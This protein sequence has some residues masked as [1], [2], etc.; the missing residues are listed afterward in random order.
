MVAALAGIVLVVHLAMRQHRA[1]M[2]RRAASIA[3]AVNAVSGRAVRAADDDGFAVRTAAGVLVEAA[4]N[5][6]QDAAGEATIRAE[7]EIP[8]DL[9]VGAEGISSRIG[10]ALTGGDVETGDDLF[11]REVLLR[12]SEARLVAILDRQTR[13]LVRAAVARGT[14]IADG[15]ASLVVRG[16][17]ENPARLADPAVLL[18]ALADAIS[19]R[20]ALPVAALLRENA[21]HDPVAAVRRRNLEILADQFPA[22]AETRAALEAAS[23]DL[24]PGVRLFA[25]ARIGTGGGGADALADIVADPYLDDTVRADALRQL[26]EAQ[27]GARTLRVVEWVLN[28][29]SAAVRALAIGAIGKARRTTAMPVLLALAAKANDP[30]EQRALAEAF[31]RMRDPAA[32]DVLLQMLEHGE[33]RV[34][35]EAARALGRT[36]GVRSVEPLRGVQGLLAGELG[37]IAEEAIVAIQGRLRH[38]SE[39]QLS[40]AEPPDE[41]GQVSL[42]SGRGAV[43]VA[44]P[45]PKRK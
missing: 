12:G 9:V 27:A 22:N 34:R 19:N 3:Q 2:Q 4:F 21:I 32:E 30:E 16:D 29:K 37:R 35:M 1:T 33:V 7:K 17:L 28:D 38:A 10:K 18:A 45:A 25:S 42:A 43:S 14:S 26:I 23:A 15:M 24:D 13:H 39:G 20:S 44:P 6:N 8:T 41:Q 5:R 40:V 11:D 36:G 31:W